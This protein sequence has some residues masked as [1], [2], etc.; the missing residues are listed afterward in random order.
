ME[1]APTEPVGASDTS[2]SASAGGR[3]GYNW[4]YFSNQAVFSRG[5]FHCVVQNFDYGIFSSKN[6]TGP[7]IYNFQMLHQGDS[8]FVPAGTVCP[9]KNYYETGT[10]FPYSKSIG[11]FNVGIG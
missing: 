5:I 11:A 1:P 4:E 6:T 3:L 2:V 10:L 7:S 8:L 9:Q